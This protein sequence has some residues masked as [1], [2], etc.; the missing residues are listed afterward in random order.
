VGFQQ[1]VCKCT[2]LNIR[3]RKLHLSTR[4]ISS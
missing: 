3:D 2:T 4:R 1:T